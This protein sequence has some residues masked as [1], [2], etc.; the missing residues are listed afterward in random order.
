M[1][2]LLIL[3]FITSSFLFSQNRMDV[4]NINNVDIIKVKMIHVVKK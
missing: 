4:L 1:K 3:I 2:K